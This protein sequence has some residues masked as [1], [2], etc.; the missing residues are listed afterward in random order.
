MEGIGNYKQIT[1]IAMCASLTWPPS[2][3]LALMCLFFPSNNCCA[4]KLRPCSVFSLATQTR[5]KAK[6]SSS[7]LVY[8]ELWQ[9]AL[10]T[11]RGER[12]A[13]EGQAPFGCEVGEAGGDGSTNPNHKLAF[14]IWS[15]EAARLARSTVLGHLT[16]YAISFW[17]LRKKYSKKRIRNKIKQKNLSAIRCVLH[18][19]K[20]IELGYSW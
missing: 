10:G 1:K 3:V 7:R 11:R 12:E 18:D 4:L 20:I 15:S 6:T 2:W 5:C 14:S 17:L 16:V 19:R 8:G 13:C 9:L